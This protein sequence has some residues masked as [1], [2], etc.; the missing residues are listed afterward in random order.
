M[1]LDAICKIHYRSKFFSGDSLKSDTRLDVEVV[2][3][4]KIIM[5]SLCEILECCVEVGVVNRCG[6]PNN[7]EN[8]NVHESSASHL[9]NF[10]GSGLNMRMSIASTQLKLEKGG[11]GCHV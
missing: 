4:P 9:Q 2:Y 1:D 7:L 5:Y 8:M 6:Y 11:V 3:I 10:I